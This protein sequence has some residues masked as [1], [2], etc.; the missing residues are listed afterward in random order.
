MM[1]KEK[2]KEFLKPDWKKGL[3]S[4]FW[5][6][7]IIIFLMHPALSEF[8]SVDQ[9]GKEKLCNIVPSFLSC[10]YLN[11]TI[12]SLVLIT[13]FFIIPLYL[14]SC[15]LAPV[16]INA[17]L[18]ETKIKLRIAL[19]SLL[20]LSIIVS[21]FLKLKC[22][23]YRCSDVII[24]CI[25]LLLIPISLFGLRKRVIHKGWIVGAIWGLISGIAFIFVFQ[26]SPSS[27]SEGLMGILIATCKSWAP[28]MD[29]LKGLVFL[30]MSIV[31]LVVSK[32]LFQGCTGYGCAWGFAYLYPL[33]VIFA[34]IIGA[35]IGHSFDLFERI[36][37]KLKNEQ[38]HLHHT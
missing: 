26:G 32:I 15:L 19:L 4:L 2:I 12:W 25:I 22:N 34:I 6:S 17:D 14:I 10:N 11:Y 16:I 18:K 37:T 7:I 13:V 27:C 36:R 31:V 24:G 29:I 33:F 1:N 21:D 8:G 9:V 35:V 3:F 30:P 23:V 38:S 5:L 20:T 28:T